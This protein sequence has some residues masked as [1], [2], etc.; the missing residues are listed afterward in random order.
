MFS[1]RSFKYIFQPQKTEAPAKSEPKAK[2]EKK[3]Q[4]AKPESKEGGQG[5]NKR[6]KKGGRVNQI[7]NGNSGDGA[8]NGQSGGGANK[9]GNGGGG[10][11]PRKDTWSGRDV[12]ISRALAGILKHGMMGFLPDEQGYLFLEDIA[13]HSHFR[14]VLKVNTD[15]LKR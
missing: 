13:Q 5:N 12:K 4:E 15:D 1:D 3:G 8:P 6:G 14:E 9:G 7:K 2:E 11:R 10:I